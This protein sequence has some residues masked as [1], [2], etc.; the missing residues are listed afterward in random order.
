MHGLCTLFTP[1]FWQFS[2]VLTRQNA[3]ATK[4]KHGHDMLTPVLSNCLKNM[5]FRLSNPSARRLLL[6]GEQQR[7]QAPRG[8]CL[9]YAAPQ[10]SPRSLYRGDAPAPLSRQR[11]PHPKPQS[12]ASRSGRA[13]KTPFHSG[14]ACAEA[15]RNAPV[16]KLG[17]SPRVQYHQALSQRFRVPYSAEFAAKFR[18]P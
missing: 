18:N 10:S 13:G 16:R 15:Q 8:C 12:C 4:A 14:L 11:P 5:C 17:Q 6:C 9:P 3:E 7:L 1:L 2:K